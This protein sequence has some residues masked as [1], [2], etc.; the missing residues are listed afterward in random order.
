MIWYLFNDLF[1][2]YPHWI[3]YH[4]PSTDAFYY[5]ILPSFLAKALYTHFNQSYKL[6]HKT[7]ANLGITAWY[8]SHWEQIL[9]NIF[10]ALIGPLLTQILADVFHQSETWG[11]HLITLYILDHGRM[12]HVCPRPHR[13]PLLFQ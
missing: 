2:F 6:H 9:F 12:R 3:A 1:Y 13:L 7:K 4:A 5:K 8:C 10:P 11:T